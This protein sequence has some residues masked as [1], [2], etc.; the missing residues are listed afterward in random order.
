LPVR[1][2]YLTINSAKCN[3]RDHK[4]YKR[5]RDRAKKRKPW[6]RPFHDVLNR[7][8]RQTLDDFRRGRDHVA[9][10]SP[11]LWAL[12]AETGEQARLSNL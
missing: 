3:Q 12:I 1:D 11:R 4:R 2:F 10:H 6:I 8:G 7:D 9:R 5:Y